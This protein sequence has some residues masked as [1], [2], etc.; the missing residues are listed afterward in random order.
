MIL[1]HLGV[2]QDADKTGT[3]ASHG[4]DLKPTEESWKE[5]AWTLCIISRS[6]LR[7]GH[8]EGSDLWIPVAK[9]QIE[10]ELDSSADLRPG[11]GGVNLIGIVQDKMYEEQQAHPTGIIQNN[12]PGSDKEYREY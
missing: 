9:E 2:I 12:F 10:T 11:E 7:S 5:Q 3:R 8:P 6:P 1:S 4:K